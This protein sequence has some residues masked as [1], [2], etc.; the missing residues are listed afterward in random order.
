MSQR[1]AWALTGITFGVALAGAV[2]F[3][4]SGRNPAVFN[5]EAARAALLRMAIPRY[6]PSNYPVRKLESEPLMEAHDPAGDGPA[7]R[8]GG[9]QIHPTS[10][11]FEYVPTA[12]NMLHFK[13]GGYF[14][15]S[16]RHGW[17]A[18]V[19]SWVSVTYSRRSPG[20]P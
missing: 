9:W 15:R 8:I 17:A 4:A 12:G 3:A 10:R 2:A 16:W 20:G 7:W 11:R 6:G 18:E 19:D 14:D 1:T 5:G 13:T